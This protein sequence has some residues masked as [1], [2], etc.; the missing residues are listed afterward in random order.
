MSII[1][2]SMSSGI[3]RG[4]YGFDLVIGDLP[5]I[6]DVVGMFAIPKG[7]HRKPCQIYWGKP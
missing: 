5:Q 1:G 2:T 6:Q 3:K 7:K 4:T